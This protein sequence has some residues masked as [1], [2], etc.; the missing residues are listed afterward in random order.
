MHTKA[1]Q[2]N[3]TTQN[4]C[5]TEATDAN[6]HAHNLR[7][8]R[9]E[10]DQISGG[11]FY[12]RID[13]LTLDDLHIFCEHTNQALRQQCNVSS[14]S[15][16]IGV[17]ANKEDCRLNGQIV[18]HKELMYHPGNAEFELV[19]PKHFDI[20]GIVINRQTLT[21]LADIHGIN[22]NAAALE[23][24]KH[25]WEASK[26]T[27]LRH[28]LQRILSPKPHILASTLQRDILLTGILNIFQQDHHITTRRAQIKHKVIVD[29]IKEYIAANN[30]T[31]ITMTELCDI[32]HVS[33]RTLHNSFETIL[34]M[35]PLR[36]IR[37]SRLNA[38][39]RSL[40][41]INPIQDWHPDE[42]TVQRVASYWGFWHPGQ[43]SVDYK[44]LFGEKPSDTLKRGLAN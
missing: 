35:S 14:D 1:T 40:L 16:W 26:L 38:A 8:W 12:G 4:W 41:Q 42:I 3:T 6:E 21:R 31:P 13:E 18:S 20:Y 37:I 34:G 2:P 33:R 44:Q 29:R 10:Y 7:N 43:F 11:T 36:Y 15:I 9:Q 23:G 22:L 30:S 17:A 32:T 28:A 24:T 25:G 5:T 19:T 27:A 39:R